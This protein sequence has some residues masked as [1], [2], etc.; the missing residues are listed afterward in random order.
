MSRYP[1]NLPANLKREAEEFASRQGVSLN[2]FIMWSVS[3]KVSA[4][5]QE[6]DDPNFPGI[7]YRRG[8]SG[9]VTPVIRGTGIRV[10]TIIVDTQ[11]G[12]D[13]EQIAAE[14]E[15]DTHKVSEAIAFYNAHQTEIDANILAEQKT[16][17]KHD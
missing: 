15:L 10:Q 13:P 4:L 16:E 17:E 1:L 9:W 6:L 12:L 7:T 5:R 11:T 3:E 14:Y 8:A 2:Q